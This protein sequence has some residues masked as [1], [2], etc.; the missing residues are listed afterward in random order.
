MHLLDSPCDQVSYFFLVPLIE[1]EG[2]QCFYRW[3]TCGPGATQAAGPTGT[4]RSRQGSRNCRAP[5]RTEC[6]SAP[7]QAAS[8]STFRPGIS[9]R[10]GP[11]SAGLAGSVPGAEDAAAVAPGARPLGNKGPFR[12]RD[13]SAAGAVAAEADRTP[14]LLGRM[15]SGETGVG[16]PS[17]LPS[18]G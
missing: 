14:A 9:G 16:C 8:F 5:A 15:G 3:C 1:R 2:R 12:S 6:A 11:T 10:R 18:G 13:A 4:G 7:D 17:G